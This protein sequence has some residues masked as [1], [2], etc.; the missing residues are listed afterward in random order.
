MAAARCRRFD[1]V[2]RRSRAVIRLDAVSFAY[3]D[4]E[5]LREVSLAIGPGEL[6]CVVGAN[7]AGKTTLLRL[8]GG[9][10]APA[11]GRVEVFGLDP[12]RV[13]RRELARKLA[14]LPQD[15]HLSFPFTVLEVVLMGRYAHGGRGLGLERQTDLDAARAAMKRCDV[16]HLEDRRFDAVSGGE[17]RRALLAQAFCQGTE[18]VLLD[19]PT[20]SLD[21]AHAIDVFTALRTETRERAATAVAVTHDLNLAARF[22]DR[23]LLVAGA[24]IAGDG[25]GAEILA[26][27]A[28]ARAF[29][30]AMHIGRLPGADTPF[31]VPR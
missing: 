25:P 4:L 7:G 9:L 27:E 12:A 28:T 5:V 23:V 11:R 31:V 1:P 18:L 3:G 20:A 14:Y 2:R 22:A 8:F 30:V 24:G 10:L 6:V 19:E 17:Q 16:A 21:P 29:G 15:Y 26:S 13:R